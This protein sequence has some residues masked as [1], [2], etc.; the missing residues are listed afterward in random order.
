MSGP[1]DDKND[2]VYHGLSGD[3]A[4]K[5][6]MDRHA[7]WESK[8]EDTLAN[9]HCEHGQYVGYNRALANRCPRCPEGKAAQGQ[10]ALTSL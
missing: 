10:P 7:R 4:E 5:M 6:I 9:R 8:A 1:L 2:P 3:K